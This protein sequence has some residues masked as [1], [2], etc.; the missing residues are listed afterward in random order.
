MSDEKRCYRICFRGMVSLLSSPDVAAPKTGHYL[1][2]GDVISTHSAEIIIESFSQPFSRATKFHENKNVINIEPNSS[3]SSAPTSKKRQR[4]KF[5]S[6]DQIL[7]AG[8]PM[9]DQKF[10]TSNANESSPKLAENRTIRHCSNRNKKSNCT[11]LFSI[12]DSENNNENDLSFPSIELHPTDDSL[13]D[14]N[15]SHLS[16]VE[17]D[18]SS[19]HALDQHESIE[20]DTTKDENLPSSEIKTRTASSVLG[21]LMISQSLSGAS[22]SCSTITQVAEPCLPPILHERGSFLYRV[23]SKHP[24]SAL[25]GPAFD[26]PPTKTVLYPG[27]I[28]QV[29]CKI[30][31]PRSPIDDMDVDD[32]SHT[33]YLRLKHRRGWIADQKFAKFSQIAC[34][35]ENN[36]KTNALVEEISLISDSRTSVSFSSSTASTLSIYSDFDVHSILSQPTPHR[37]KRHRRPVSQVL[38]SSN[39]SSVCSFPHSHFEGHLHKVQPSYSD[40]KSVVQGISATECAS[41]DCQSRSQESVHSVV[42]CSPSLTAQEKSPHSCVSSPSRSKMKANIFLFRVTAPKGLKVLDNPHF[43]VRS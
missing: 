24:I 40:S 11:T 26:A 10:I 8:L 25:N 5:V 22:V 15:V 38:S 14:L 17:D 6:V 31:F 42:S 1:C 16:A 27:Q 20:S 30:Q 35:G 19:L 36:N 18:E 13:H 21:Y 34:D 29:E 9:T 32:D 28:I 41:I 4:V 12:I 37:S 43:Q 39:N 33:I 23:C 2:Y 7:T 3:S